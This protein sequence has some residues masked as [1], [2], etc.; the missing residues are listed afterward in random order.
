MFISPCLVLTTTA[1]LG[2]KNVSD[3]RWLS[4]HHI[5]ALSMLNYFFL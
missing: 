3:A 5:L 2:P 1:M 4:N